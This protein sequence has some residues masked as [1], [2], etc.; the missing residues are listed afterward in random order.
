MNAGDAA[1]EREDFEA[2]VREYA[3]AE[4][5]APEI[6]E[7]PF[8]HAVTLAASGHVE[9]SLPIFRRVFEREPIWADL[10][11]RLP[12]AD[13]LPHDPALVERI[14]AQRREAR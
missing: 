13:I 1:M 14:L 8:W 2:A 10:V 9:E 5:Y 11:T 4:Q 3:A 12:E 7:I 6:I